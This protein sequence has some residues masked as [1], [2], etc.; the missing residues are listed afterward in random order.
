MTMPPLHA[1]EH[2][3]LRD[4]DEL[5]RL[6][7]RGPLES[8]PWQSF[9]PH[10]RDRFDAWA[11][12]LVLRPP[13]AGDSGVILNQ[14]RPASG[15]DT[16]LTVRLADPSDW[17]SLAYREQF[18][19]L[20]PFINLPP[21]KVV[22]LQELLPMPELLASEYYHQYLKPAG[23]LYILG[24]DIG[25]PGGPWAR[26]RLSRGPDEAPFSE[27]DKALAALLLPHLEQAIQLHYRL[28]RVESER[29]LY[30]GAVEQLAV[31]T[32]LL[33][34]HGKV[35]KCN[36]LATRIL[37][38]NDGLR[39]HDGRLE[40]ADRQRGRE[41]Q[42]SID[43]VLASA[44]RGEPAVVQALRVRRPSGRPELGLLV[45]PVPHSEWAEGQAFPSAVIFISDPEQSSTA[46]QQM[47]AQLFGL[48]RAESALATLLA[49]GL[50]L[51]EVA[52]QLHVSLHTARAQLKSV[53]A[54]TGATR[55]AELVRLLV[56]S[57]AALG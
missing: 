20:D 44:L 9:L 27:A 17:Q 18:F 6:L 15:A 13:A 3:P 25:A 10:C 38:E 46:S 40:L 28:N 16:N 55:Q 24:A 31:G 41:L 22:T 5:L 54:K 43:S 57:V 21:G 56:K 30:A 42:A 23:V 32:I 29:D 4:Y 53:F 14:V 37:D 45:R 51:Q 34:E 12:S 50:S 35:T 49:N 52:E 1:P 26:F 48:T 19:A 47:L 7:Y 36:Q 2:L 39:L 11:I 33:D 8:M